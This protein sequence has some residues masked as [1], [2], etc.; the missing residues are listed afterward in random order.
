MKP[1]SVSSQI[2]GFLAKYSAPI[3]KQLRQARTK[4]RALFPKGCELVYD[5]YNALVFGFGPTERAS[6]AVVSLAGYPRW[7][8]LFFLNGASLPDP[9][10]LLQGSG[11]RVRSIRLLAAEDLDRAEVLRLI[12]QASAPLLAKFADAPAL[13]TLVKSVSAKQRARRASDPVRPKPMAS[14]KVAQI[15]RYALSLPGTTE[16]P[17]FEYSSF[18]VCGKIFVTVPPDEK[19]IHVFVAD[20][21]RER[22][23]AIHPKVL[24]KLV[25][26]GRVRGLRVSLSRAPAGVVNDLIRAAWE[27]KAPKRLVETSQKPVP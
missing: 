7:V 14:T 3:A 9:H 20:E 5:N 11:A 27:R 8:T 2:E 24:E 18:R 25:W 6:D 4:M 10:R 19:H 26:G 23:L 16:E 21:E 13:Y 17:H 12:N 15:R 22:A 1:P